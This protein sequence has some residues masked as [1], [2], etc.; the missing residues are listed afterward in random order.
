MV[1]QSFKKWCHLFKILLDNDNEIEFSVQLLNFIWRKLYIFNVYKYH[2]IYHYPKQLLSYLEPLK[3]TVRSRKLILKLTFLLF[4]RT[5]LMND[6]NSNGF[7]HIEWSNFWNYRRCF[8]W[9]HP[10]VLS[11]EILQKI[12]LDGQMLMILSYDF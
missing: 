11:F 4:W 8:L 3:F 1:L 12:N 5:G 6:I 7:F 9:H 10:K 2:N